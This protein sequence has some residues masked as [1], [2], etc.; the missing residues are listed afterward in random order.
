M[1]ST[2]ER[3]NRLQYLTNE[4][5]FHDPNKNFA[6]LVESNRN[7]FKGFKVVYSTFNINNTFSGTCL[8]SIEDD[9]AVLK[10]F[11]YGTG[12]LYY[13]DELYE[14]TK[15]EGRIDIPIDYSLSLDSNVAEKFRIWEKGGDL[16]AEK[17]R[18]EELVHFIKDT[19]VDDKGQGFNFD[20]NFFIIENLLDSMKE[21][22]HR[23][24][25]SIRALKRFDHLHYE[26]KKFDIDKPRFTETREEAGKRAIETLHTYH[27]SNE[28]FKFLHRRKGLYLI[29]LKAV[30]LKQQRSLTLSE[31]MNELT[32]FSLNSLGKFAKNELYYCWK[33]LKYGDKLRFFSDPIS[34]LNKKSLSKI[35]GM[36]WD[37]FAFRYQETLASK[38]NIGEFYVPFFAS[39][40]NRFVDLAAACPIRVIIIDDQDKR[41]ITLH[42]DEAEFQQELNSSLSPETLNTL[43]DP[44]AKIARMNST[45]TDKKLD[46]LISSLEVE[47]N[48]LC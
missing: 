16:S 7:L 35:K 47:I 20:Y 22:N 27:S 37:L 17:S 5:M 42:L 25:N 44:K 8:K 4:I 26:R 11:F 1:E 33:M 14:K 43:Q 45:V 30:V 28:G 24:F 29:L 40:D 10:K 18:F 21:N 12:L 6:A 3:F 15:V 36:S 34:Q 38:A 31:K 46:T 13:T 9:C 23:P 39:F 2:S 19:K 48:K 41:V 32:L